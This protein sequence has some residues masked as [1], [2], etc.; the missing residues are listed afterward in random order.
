MTAA[1]EGV[2]R[3][4]A[5]TVLNMPIHA[6]LG[7]LSLI[8]RLKIGKLKDSVRSSGA[9]TQ[10]DLL[11]YLSDDSSPLS[12]LHS[13]PVLSPMNSDEDHLDHQLELK[14]EIEEYE[15]PS[16]PSPVK[17]PRP[18]SSSKKSPY[19]P[20]I[21]RGKVSCIPFPSLENTSFGL[22]QERL[23]HDPFRLLIATIFLNKTRGSVSMPVFFN[24]MT[25]YPTIAD[26]AAA[27]HGDLLEMIQHLGLQ[28]QRA[29][30]CIRLAQAWLESPPQKGKR[31]RRIHY[32]KKDD[33]KDVKA[34]DDPINEED[35]RVA[36]EI[37][38]LPGIGAYA[39]D[40]WRIFCRD[41]L[42]GRPTGLL[43]ELTP[44]SI[45][46]E[47]G[48]EWARVLPL[49]KELRAYLRWRWLRLGWEFNATTGERKAI[50]QKLYMKVKGGGVILEG[51]QH[52]SVEGVLDDNGKADVAMLIAEDCEMVDDGDSRKSDM[53]KDKEQKDPALKDLDTASIEVTTIADTVT[54]TTSGGREEMITRAVLHESP[55]GATM[56]ERVTLTSENII[57]SVEQNA[58]G[59]E[60][61]SKHSPAKKPAVQPGLAEPEEE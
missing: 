61:T 38:H 18:K 42:R 14:N 52:W 41:E 29:K 35:P 8:V 51:D 45:E 3:F 55:R 31:Y 28:N 17:K 39:I 57:A 33:G 44:E 12:S 15:L 9:G 10:L 21:P 53:A 50:D 20:E 34:G 5:D 59:N 49:D 25:R 40:S 4:T 36:W 13:S 56:E 26:L 22:V 23:C 27:K 19:F 46:A 58:A 47:M 60:A 2:S 54:A 32:P 48:K 43:E 24:V 7:R 6:E 30:K 16:T 37:G 11:E 1:D